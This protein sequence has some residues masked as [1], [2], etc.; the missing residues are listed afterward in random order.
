MQAWTFE[1][2]LLVAALI[3]WAVIAAL[4]LAWGPPLGHDESAFAL[5]GRG[6]GGWLYRSRGIAALAHVGLALGGADWQMRLVMAVVNFGVV[7]AV[8]AVGR[9]VFSPRTGAWAAAV[10][11]TAH[12]MAARSAELLGDLSG[13]AGVV[14]GVAVLAGELARPGG[15]RW[16]LVLAAPAFAAAFYFRY[17]SAPVIAIAGLAALGLWW[18]AILARPA[19]VIV[20]ALVLAALL[21]PHFRDSITVTGSALGVLK[22]SSGVPRRAYWG[23]GLVTYLTSD[24]FVYYGAIV[25]PVIVGGL[26]GLVVH[27]R[28]RAAWFVAIVAIGQVVAIGIQSHGQPRYVFIAVALFVVLGAEA[29]RALV[30]P[31]LGRFATRLGLA[32]VGLAWL[33]LAVA[34][35]PYNLRITNSRQTLMAAA[36][37]IRADHAAHPGAPCTVL[38]LVAWQLMWYTGCDGYVTRAMGHDVPGQ[39]DARYLVSTPYGSVDGAQFAAERG[40]TARE[41]PTGQPHSRVWLLH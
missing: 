8:Y 39:P 14:A 33:A 31:R 13:M 34:I 24:P 17:G 4:N 22:F 25:A 26:V 1:R 27:F 36:A 40:L 3:G 7:L 28:T 41:L 6:A 38:S 32:A 29:W 16:R 35:V 11:V 18:R 9:A 23:E 5:V 21:V 30:A 37:T 2:K 19:P 12:P 15:P 20:T 10:I